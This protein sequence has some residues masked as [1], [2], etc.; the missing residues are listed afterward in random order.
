MADTEPLGEQG[1]PLLKNLVKDTDSHDFYFTYHHSAGDSMT[2]MN[3][4][5]LDDNVVG[6]ASLFFLIADSE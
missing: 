6:L 5:D 3:P 1:I 4:D 2:M